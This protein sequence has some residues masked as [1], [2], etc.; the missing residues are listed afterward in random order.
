MDP[1]DETLSLVIPA[2][3]E[4]AGIVDAV[5]E[6]A[7]ALRR[8][9]RPFELLVVDDGSQDATAHMVQSLVRDVSQLRLLRHRAN[10]GY[11]AALRTGFMAARG[12]Y[13]AF[14]DADRQFDL[15]ELGGLLSLARD[16]DVVA[17]YRL[18]RQDAR[19]RKFYSR[20]YNLLARLL[21]GVPVR[22]IDCALKVF[23]RDALAQLLPEASGFFVNTEML[24][25][26]HELQ[27]SIVEVGVRHRPRLRGCSKVSV[28]DIPRTLAVLLPFWWSHRSRL[29]Q[30][31]P[32]P[33]PMDVAGARTSNANRVTHTH[34]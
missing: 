3:N 28:H 14:T 32:A 33:A 1:V 16:H 7:T 27:M 24:T 8:L 18:D 4:E 17:G 19:L 5:M 12:D 2:Y 11:G 9:Q 34:L 13:V 25:R 31:H 6:A 10:R 26:A 29:R 21:L 15:R 30:R 20:G 22:D 23:R